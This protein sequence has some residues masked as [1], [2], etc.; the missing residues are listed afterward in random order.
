MLAVSAGEP[1]TI[2]EALQDQKWVAAMN[3]EHSALL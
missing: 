2:D 3:T 1:N